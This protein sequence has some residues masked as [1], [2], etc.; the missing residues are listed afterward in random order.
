LW[1]APSHSL[2]LSLLLPLLLP[3]FLTRWRLLEPR[4]FR[5]GTQ[6][7]LLPPPRILASAEALGPPSASLFYCRAAIH[8]SFLS[9]ASSS[10]GRRN[11]NTICPLNLCFQSGA[12]ALGEGVGAQES[13]WAQCGL[14]Q[15][16]SMVGRPM[17]SPSSPHTHFMLVAQ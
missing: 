2:A 16:Y 5:P 13:C 15:L 3:H 11:E 9:K 4:A 6:S 8:F 14:G 17:L 12:H 7:F 1:E 10:T